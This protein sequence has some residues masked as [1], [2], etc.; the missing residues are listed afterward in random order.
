MSDK[1]VFLS[2]M[3]VYTLASFRFIRQKWASII[4]VPARSGRSGEAQVE[5]LEGRSVSNKRRIL[6]VLLRPPICLTY[7]AK[8]V[9]ISQTSQNCG[10][11]MQ[12][13]VVVARRCFRPRWIPC[14]Q[15]VYRTH[16]IRRGSWAFSYIPREFTKNIF[17]GPRQNCA[18]TTSSRKFPTRL[19]RNT[20]RPRLRC[21]D[22]LAMRLR[23]R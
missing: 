9:G 14:N 1:S 18:T 15:R 3:N 6:H 12:S 19:Q 11:R 23:M 20:R 22:V 5:N 2:L 7:S 4:Y 8:R 13:E 16:L 10:C 21:L 17:R